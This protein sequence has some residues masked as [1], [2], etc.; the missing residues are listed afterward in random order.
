V[1]RLDKAD[2]TE[3]HLSYQSYRVPGLRCACNRPSFPELSCHFMFK[4]QTEINSLGTCQQNRQQ[5]KCSK[6]DRQ[7]LLKFPFFPCSSKGISKLHM[8][9]GYRYSNCLSI[10]FGSEKQDTTHNNHMVQT[11]ERVSDNSY[12]MY[13]YNSVTKVKKNVFK[14]AARILNKNASS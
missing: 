9:C 4:Q 10:F 14:Q 8:L 1:K 7:F 11:P 13:F 5:Y 12:L 6:M 2:K 3:N